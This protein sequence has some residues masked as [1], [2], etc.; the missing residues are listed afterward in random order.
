MTHTYN[1]YID[2]SGEFKDDVLKKGLNPSLV[3]G[4]LSLEGAITDEVLACVPDKY[5]GCV[6]KD[7][8]LRFTILD[9]LLEAGGE[10]VIFENKERIK[11]IDGDT[12]YLNIISEGLVKLMQELN[13]RHPGEQV[14]LNALVAWRESMNDE[15]DSKNGHLI[16]KDEYT[17]RVMEKLYIAAGKAHISNVNYKIELGSA[18]HDKRLMLADAICNTYITRDAKVKFTAAERERIEELFRD[19]HVYPVFE[20][21]AIGYMRRL[22]GDMRY[23]ELAYTL[24]LLKAL[25]DPADKLL[26]ML[27]EELRIMPPEN[28]KLVLTQMSLHIAH[29]VYE[30]DYYEGIRFAENLKQLI[31]IPLGDKAA[32]WVFDTDFYILTMYD[33]LGNVGACCA[34]M[35]KCDANIAVADSSW[36]H[37]DYYLTY[38]VRRLNV[39]MGRYDFEGVL[40]HGKKLLQILN[41]TKA[42]FSMIGVYEGSGTEIKSELRGKVLSIMVEAY[43]NLI[44]NNPALEAETL[45]ASDESIAEFGSNSGRQY[46]FRSMLMLELNRPQEAL[47]CL[48]QAVGLAAEDFEGFMAGKPDDFLLWHY[49][50]VCLALKR[51]GDP[52][53][54]EMYRALMANSRFTE[55]LKTAAG[56]LHPWQMIFWNMAYLADDK[57]YML[58]ALSVAK[59][60]KEN[61]SLRSFGISIRADMLQRARTEKNTEE[62]LKLYRRFMKEELPETMRAYFAFDDTAPISDTTL[63]R[64]AHAYL[65]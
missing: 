46:Q 36:E 6:D 31:L 59:G 1:I 44:R 2:E 29:F 37:I 18:R 63:T 61:I 19:A 11:V 50:D 9:T 22:L 26:E 41:D 51:N 24:C 33:H 12:T 32:Y 64:L 8:D 25:D 23:A 60:K 28:L 34:Y 16:Y 62:F 49:T 20:N 55:E 65:K 21:G 43:C 14:V 54:A 48:M 42:L 52:R 15:D 3:G 27:R 47:E 13:A 35:D 4:V 39:L 45:K 53:A 56:R 57:T 10:F 5:H 30:R 7:T 58:A 17:N 40:T 38:K